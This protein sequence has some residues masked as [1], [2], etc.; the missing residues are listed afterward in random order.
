MLIDWKNQYHLDVLPKATYRFNVIHIKI[1]MSFFIELKQLILN[2][3]GITCMLSR[4]STSLCDPVLLCLQDSLSKNTGVS[5]HF[6]LQRIFPTEGS[7]TSLLHLLH[8]Q[9]GSLPLAPTGKLE[10]QMTPNKQNNFKREE[11]SWG[12]TLPDFKLY[13]K[14]PVL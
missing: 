2:L 3:F 10:P 5:C 14:L 11:Q 7:N 4:F 12:I 13:Y 9:A 8:W 1:P 6:F